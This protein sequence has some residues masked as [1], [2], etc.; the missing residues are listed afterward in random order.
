MKFAEIVIHPLAAFS[1][2]LKGDTIFGHFCWQLAYDPTLAN[3]SLSELL[4]GY[5]E[6]PFVVFSSAFPRFQWEGKTAWFI[7]KPALPSHFFG[8]RK[9][10]CFETVS[11]RKENKRKR[12]MI[13]QEEME[14]CLNTEYF[15]DREAFELLRKALPEDERFPFPENP[16]SFH[17]TQAQPHNSINRLTFTT[18]EGFAPY[19]LE[20]LWYFPGL[21][22]SIFCLFREE[23]INLSGLE[24]AFRRM[25]KMGFGRDASWGLGRFFV[26]A[27]RELPLPKQAKDLYALAPFVPN[28]DELEDIWY[29][30]FVRFGKHGGPLA[31]S[32]NPFKEPVLMA[33]EGAV[34]RLKNSSGPYIGQAI[35]NISKILSETVM[36][37]YSIVLPF[38]WRKP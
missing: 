2:P 24:N 3:G 10:D 6:F 14:I 25:G 1:T 16:L 7:P 27:V 22:L 9:G 38:R 29:H 20:N 4:S 30:P 28:E 31:L 18:G 8:R 19:Q 12:W 37:G 36:Q 11:Q 5:Y 15:T 21:R 23:A 26:E 13:L 17:I 32:D 34:L 35:G 33:D